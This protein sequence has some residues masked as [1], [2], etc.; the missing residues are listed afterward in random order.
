M[1][2]VICFTDSLGSGGAQRQL[3]GLAC[4]LKEKG[5]DVSVL[6][7]HDIPF[8]KPVLDRAEIKSVVLFSKNYIQRIWKIYKYLKNNNDAIIIA[9]QETPSLISCLLRP[10]INYSKL[11]VSERNTTQSLTKKDTLRFWAYRFA[12]YIVPNSFSQANFISKNFPKLAKKVTTITNFVD[13]EYFHPTDRSNFMQRRT[14]TIVVVGSNKPQKNFYRFMDAIKIV[15]NEEIQLHVRWFGILPEYLE[16]HRAYVDSLDLGRFVSI[17]GPTPDISIEY[18][19]ADFFC[20]PSLFEGFPNVLCE[21]MSCGLPIGC[22]DV[23]DNP[24]IMSNTNG[25]IL[26]NPLNIEDMARAIKCLVSIS[27]EEWHKYSVMNR[28]V[29]ENLFSKTAFI[30]KYCKLL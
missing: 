17:Y 24:Y 18:Q 4:M 29:A 6:L 2:K 9:Y 23:C 21:A 15:C 14:N 20:L 27:N 30:N 10:F 3:A 8:Y 5:Y 16:E 13:T 26:F 12:D 28:S 22:S 19:S 1:K 11:I 7:Y 25:G